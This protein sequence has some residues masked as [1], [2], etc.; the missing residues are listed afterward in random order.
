MKARIAA[1]CLLLALGACATPQP[2]DVQLFIACKSYERALTALALLKPTL[3]NA[4]IKTVI[5]VIHVAGPLCRGGGAAGSGN[6][7]LAA[8][9]TVRNALQKLVMVQQQAEGK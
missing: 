4:Q 3:K 2:P 1:L 6:T 9:T 8:V 5:Q 7:I